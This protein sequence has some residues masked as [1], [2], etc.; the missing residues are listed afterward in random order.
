[1]KVGELRILGGK[2]GLVNAT[3]LKKDELV[4]EIVK[5]IENN[6][7]DEISRNVNKDSQKK[8]PGRPPKK[9]KAVVMNDS[10]SENTQPQSVSAE[11]G[12]DMTTVALLYNFSNKYNFNRKKALNQTNRERFLRG[13]RRSRRPP[14]RRRKILLWTITQKK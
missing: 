1:M 11:P 7:I 9:D 6:T 8:R 4:V 2:L 10:S 3:T 13:Y 14:R 12:L 5:L